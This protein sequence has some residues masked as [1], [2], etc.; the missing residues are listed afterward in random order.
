MLPQCILADNRQLFF[1]SRKK[2]WPQE[3]SLKFVKLGSYLPIDLLTWLSSYLYCETIFKFWWTFFWLKKKR[4]GMQRFC[5]A[6]R[7]RYLESPKIHCCSKNLNL[8]EIS[9]M[10]KIYFWAKKAVA[11]NLRETHFGLKFFK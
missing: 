1:V 6:K 4:L 11:Q 5:L 7:V 8:D 9:F 2:F 10:V 3:K